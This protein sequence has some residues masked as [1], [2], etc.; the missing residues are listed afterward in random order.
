MNLLAFLLEIISVPLIE[1]FRRSSEKIKMK[2]FSRYHE[3][4]R[5]FLVPSSICASKIFIIE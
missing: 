3:E 1:L 5:T 4:S 2:M